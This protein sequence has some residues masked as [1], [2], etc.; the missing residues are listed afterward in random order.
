VAIKRFPNLHNDDDHEG[1]AEA[2]EGVPVHAPGSLEDVTPAQH[3]RPLPLPSFDKILS[4]PPAH[5]PVRISESAASG[6]PEVSVPAAPPER[7][8]VTFEPPDHGFSRT[9]VR[10]AG[11][12]RSVPEVK[13]ATA[14]EITTTRPPTQAE[15]EAVI[16]T[17]HPVELALFPRNQELP[18]G[19]PS[20]PTI[21]PTGHALPIAR[22]PE[23][24]VS[25]EPPPGFTPPLPMTAEA[26]PPGVELTGET[27]RPLARPVP[28]DHPPDSPLPALPIVDALRTDVP[29][30]EH[31]VPA[32]HSADGP[33]HDT[34]AGE[35]VGLRESAV[36][37][38][39]AAA[40]AAL[41]LFP[42]APPAPAP[43]A[44]VPDQGE[45]PTGQSLQFPASF[46]PPH[47]EFL[48][49]PMSGEGMFAN[50][51]FDGASHPANTY[52]F[53]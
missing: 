21:E 4:G 11:V 31:G 45:L 15:V 13:P 12:A 52:W 49:A 34:P 51:G 38:T 14:V 40:A 47:T 29:L 32:A 42:T 10:D 18:L 36:P 6:P 44:D 35:E 17:I 3:V 48:N 27:G 23:F 25:H 50:R 41:G 28:P 46:A 30:A 19:I 7:P 37:G 2:R 39:V 43:H 26:L 9:E 33:H 22:P 24:G 8:R 20:V 5:E 53:E 1:V 16:P